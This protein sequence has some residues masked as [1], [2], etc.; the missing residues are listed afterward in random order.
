[1]PDGALVLFAG[2][3]SLIAY[4]L[5]ASEKTA[6][7]GEVPDVRFR[8][9]ASLALAVA[10]AAAAIA[11]SG[12]PPVPPQNP[13]TPTFRTQA[14]YVRVDVYPTAAGQ[15]VMDLR[16]E[17]FDVSEDGAPQEIRTFEHVVVSPAG[18]Q[19]QRSEPSTIDQSQQLAANPR[20]RVFILFLD[21]PHVT[22]DGAWHIREP[23]IRL[24]DRILGPDDLVGIMTPKMSAADVVLARKTQVL[25]SGLRDRWPWGERYT[26][27]LDDRE[28]LYQDCYPWEGTKDV[29]AEMTARRRERATLDALNELVLYMRDVREER[30]AILTISEGWLL[31]RQNGDL[32]RLRVISPSGQTEPVPTGAPVSVGP[33]GK[34]TT[35][36]PNRATGG[37]T[38]SDCDADRRYLSQ[39]DDELYFRDIMGEANRGNASFYTVD[40]RGLAVFDTPIGPQKLDIVQD[41]RSLRTRLDS[42]LTLAGN[43]DGIAVINNNDLDKGLKRIAD[44]LTSYYLLGYYAT[45][46]RLDGKFRTIKVRVKRPGVEVRARKGYRA[47]TEA[48][49]AAARTSAAP[50]AESVPGLG[51][52]IG[53]LARLRPDMRFL[54]NVAAAGIGSATTTVWVAGELPSIA[55]ADPWLKGS[56]ADLEV[57]AGG[58]T[59]TAQ[60]TLAPGQRSFAV[61]VRL[62]KPVTSGPIEVRAKLA[63]TDPDAGHLGDN[64]RIDNAAGPAQPMI[65]RRGPSTANRMMPAASFQFSRTERARLEFPVAAAVKADSARLLD[66][67]GQALAVPVTLGERVDEA[68]GQRWLTADVTLAAL[69]AGDY[70]IEVTVSGPSGNQ[71]LVTALRVGR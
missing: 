31:Y 42:L 68:T 14:N 53:T 19:S 11:Q 70:A 64:V 62:S 10:A 51:S 55:A 8:I 47:P 60:I 29:V 44:D 41:A 13:Q 5:T 56:I 12:A 22:I 63:G 59:T 39:L 45:N 35:R 9:T 27:E 1:M 28:K 7:A 54:V 16:A 15:P 50:V 21:V 58:T 36:N 43:T 18:P 17:D 61:P 23:L 48:E 24:I 40:P 66:K 6:P 37:A 57:I 34:L 65:F 46:A 26:L 38:R 71:R 33:D 20:N 52:A 49:V 67:S 4:T 25:A 69:G 3:L 30:K 2:P 32:T